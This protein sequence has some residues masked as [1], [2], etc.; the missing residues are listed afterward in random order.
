VG[1]AVASAFSV[2][3]S[4]V[5]VWEEEQGSV[6]DLAMP[7]PEEHKAKED[8]EMI[9]RLRRKAELQK[10]MTRPTTYRS[11]FQSEISLK[12]RSRKE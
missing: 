5:P 1:A 3:V 9:E 8:A 7:S 4:S 2:V 6:E 12:W 11:S 10:Q